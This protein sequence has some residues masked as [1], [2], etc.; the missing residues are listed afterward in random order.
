D[1]DGVAHLVS[2][3]GWTEA[4]AIAAVA[5][6]PPLPRLELG[7]W[8]ERQWSLVAD[9]PPDITSRSAF[10]AVRTL[11]A[12]SRTVDHWRRAERER[13]ALWPMDPVDDATHGVFESGPMRELVRTIRRVAQT[14]VTILLTGETGTG[15]DV[16]AR[17]VHEYSPRAN[18][19]FVPFS[20][21][22]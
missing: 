3:H 13:S 2:S 11:A 8:R 21:T 14:P 5:I 15:K 12:C 9:V 19:M 18:K 20:C 17:L 22:A 6:T 10:V 1:S 7:S 4:E 16:L